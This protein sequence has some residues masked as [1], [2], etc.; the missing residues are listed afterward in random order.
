MVLFP[1]VEDLE[2]IEP[3]WRGPLGVLPPLLLPIPPATTAPGL[4]SSSPL[5]RWW[6]P[7]STSRAARSTKNCHRLRRLRYS[8]THIHSHDTLLFRLF[9]LGALPSSRA[10]RSAA[11]WMSWKRSTYSCRI[12]IPSPHSPVRIRPSNLPV[13]RQYSDTRVTH[14]TICSS[15]RK[16]VAKATRSSKYRCE[17]SVMYWKLSASRRGDELL[18]LPLGMPLSCICKTCKTSQY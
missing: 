6:F 16:K 4:F 10:T 15:G 11:D 14:A 9:M 2:P 18:A 17:S 1:P 12:R 8:C 5:S 7:S 13:S 3:P